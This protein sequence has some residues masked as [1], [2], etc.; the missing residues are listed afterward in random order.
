MSG[1]LTQKNK[2]KMIDKAR[3]VIILCLGDKSLREVA[4]E[5]TIV[6]IWVKL[7][8]LYM[9]KSLES[10]LC[11]KQQI[12]SFKMTKARLIQE[13]LED[14]NKILDDSENIEA[15]LEDEDK[16][17]LILNYLPKSFENFKDVILY[18]KDQAITLEDVHSS[19]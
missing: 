3:N 13:Q 2:N 17:F 6:A 19:I 16:V 14:F 8:S 11:L 9:T 10:R 7:E 5:K 15:K 18:V 12:Y 4:R 1:S